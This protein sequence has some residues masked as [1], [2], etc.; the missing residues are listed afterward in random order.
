M[1]LEQSSPPLS[2][3]PGSFLDNV[4]QTARIRRDKFRAGWASGLGYGEKDLEAE[5]FLGNEIYRMIT[6]ID[7]VTGD[8]MG[9]LATVINALAL[10]NAFEENG[11]YTRL[12]T[13]I[14]MDEMAEQYGMEVALVFSADP[15]V[16]L[17]QAWAVFV[18]AFILSF[19]P[20]LVLFRLSPV[21]A[22]RKG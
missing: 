5:K 17:E 11:M 2:I 19:Y 18:I 3:T 10:Q 15:K 21:D 6:G 12:M 8:Q 13:A 9:M 14:K 20:L 16:F 1:G 4:I 7:R 22:M